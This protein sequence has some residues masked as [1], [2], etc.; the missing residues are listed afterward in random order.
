MAQYNLTA[1]Q[2]QDLQ[3]K[4][5]QDDRAGFY[6]LLYNDT[7]QAGAPSSTVAELAQISSL[8]GFCGNA[9]I[10]ANMLAEAETGTQYPGP[11][12]AFSLEIARDEFSAIQRAGGSFDDTQMVQVGQS[13]W[14]DQ[15]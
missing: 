9:A 6:L 7:V 5:D 10:F 8:S 1:T 2:L 14:N 15:G 13:A 12:T 3:N 11:L 4:L